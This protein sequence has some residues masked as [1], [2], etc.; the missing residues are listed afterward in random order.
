MAFVHYN[1]T[2]NIELVDYIVAPISVAYRSALVD[3]MISLRLSN[4]DFINELRFIP[5][6][7]DEE[8]DY[9]VILTLETKELE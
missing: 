9:R 1:Q 6:L 8:K 3:S 7:Q 5:N 4:S 2:R